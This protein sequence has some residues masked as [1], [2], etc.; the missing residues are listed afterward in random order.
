MCAFAYD[1]FPSN[2]QQNWSSSEELTIKSTVKCII[3]TI[4]LQ[5]AA[6]LFSSS[7]GSLSNDG[8]DGN[9]NDKKV[10]TKQ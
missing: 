3:C 4:I 7:L 8:G 6:S 1:S 9:E 5:M 2:K 10:I